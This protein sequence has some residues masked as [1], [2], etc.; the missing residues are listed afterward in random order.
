MNKQPEDLNLLDFLAKT[1]YF[2]QIVKPEKPEK[3]IAFG[4]GF[5]IE[6]NSH[7]FFLTAD[8]NIHIEDHKLNERTGIDNNVEIF[9]NISDK[10][11]FRT[12][13]TPIGGFYYMEKFDIIKP[14]DAPELFDVALSLI[15]IKK[16]Q[17]PFLTDD[18]IVSS[19]GEQLVTPG[20]PKLMFTEILLVE[21]TLVDKYFVFG[22]IRPYFQ[23]LFLHRKFTLKE[24]ITFIGE[25]GDY[26][27]FNS[28]AEI[29]DYDDWAGLSGSPMVNQNGECVGVLCSIIE[30]SKSLWV[31][32]LSK[33]KP[34][35]DI[36]I[37][38]KDK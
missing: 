8:H 35:L 1:H 38:Q 16:L 15:D 23:G 25:F 26:L 32:P 9:N 12:I 22:K 10:E 17:A 14:N 18:N 21:P 3:P 11:N 4:S 27:L 5:F 29:R 7:H 33:I 31:K 36:A 24:N 2:I 28:D 30:N 20:E 37:L 34:L 19:N 13:V 6:Y